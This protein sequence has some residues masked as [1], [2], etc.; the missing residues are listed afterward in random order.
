MA[1]CSQTGMHCTGLPLGGYNHAHG[2]CIKHEKHA[3][4]EKVWRWKV[5]LEWWVF[6]GSAIPAIM[7]PEVTR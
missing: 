2:T 1:Q 4:N 5:K 6:I 7:T 3:G